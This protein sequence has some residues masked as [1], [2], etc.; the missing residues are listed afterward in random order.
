M[1]PS[2]FDETTHLANMHWLI[3]FGDAFGQW[4][5]DLSLWPDV[6]MAK[7]R[8]RDVSNEMFRQKEEIWEYFFLWLVIPEN[9]AAANFCTNLNTASLLVHIIEIF[10]FT[11][12]LLYA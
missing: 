6:V 1:Q 2:P 3:L 8:K 7:R 4:N 11:Q 10:S 5:L 9:F 12:R